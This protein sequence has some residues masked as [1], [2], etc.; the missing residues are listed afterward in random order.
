MTARLAA[1]RVLVALERGRTTL[2]REI[3]EDRSDLQDP[4]DRGLLL[5][6]V[7]GALRWQA[8]LDA[9]LA[10][11][12]KRPI[13]AL[14]P[15]VRAVLRAGAYQL[16]YLDRLPPHAV[17]HESVEVVRQLKHSRA[18]GFVN[19][20]L[21]GLLR[22]GDA[23]KAL[24]AKPADASNRDTALDYLSVTLSH[25]R[26]LVARWLDRFGF[27]A[28]ARWCEFNNTSP[29]VTI[30]P[31]SGESA[32]VL[33]HDLMERGVGAVLSAFAP[34]SI[35]LPAGSLGRLDEDL[36]RRIVI[37]DE[38]SQIVAFSAGAA[39]GLR[40]LDVC[41]APGGKT[42]LLQN[43]VGPGG[44]VIAGDHRPARVRLL[45]SRLR[46]LGAPAPVLALDAAVPLPFT[47]T[48]DRVLLDAPCSGLGT[49]R[50]DPD[51]KWTRTPEDLARFAEIQV[52]MLQSASA[53]VRP[54]G[55]LTYATCSSEPDENESV[56]ERFLQSTTG[57]RRE[58][59]TL[60][61]AQAAAERLIDEHG[62]LHTLPFRDDVDAFFAARLVRSATA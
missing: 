9:C 46:A 62:Y 32:S 20:V 29:A 39:S 8:A 16:L 55:V 54:G 48:F 24:P 12:S 36:R 17:V 19:A 4:R 15:E 51:L 42:A 44:L 58:P 3:E 11:R 23:R 27:D 2:S 25:P 33:L 41:A 47:D 43:A 30:R 31:M 60:P 14:A 18:A 56:V 13:A 50:R 45:Q 26:W 52:H 38:G 28:S 57:F 7:A 22:G 61:A 40:V 21:R 53:V 6:I 5:E 1:A 34:E 49:L 59:V 37:Q 35:R 10:T